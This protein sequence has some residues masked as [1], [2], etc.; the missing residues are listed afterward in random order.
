M[1]VENM[2]VKLTAPVAGKKVPPP[3][4]NI[5]PAISSIPSFITTDLSNSFSDSNMGDLPFI[6]MDWS[7]TDT[8]LDLNDGLDHGKALSPHDLL[9]V[10]G[11]SPSHNDSS[12]IHGSEPNLNSLG[13]GQD[14]LDAN[15]NPSAMNLDVS[16][17]LDVIMPST[18]LTP[19]SANAPV[20]FPSDPILTPKPQDVLDLFNMD[21]S[22]LYTPTDI[23]N[24]IIFDKF[25]DS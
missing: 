7:D 18:G 1:K 5:T 17:W 22:D 19:L 13:L 6:A 20:S 12:S 16:D 21:E 2:D 24:G 8:A 10:N 3:P 23:Q 14:M 15:D 9:N 25:G 11:S 4:I